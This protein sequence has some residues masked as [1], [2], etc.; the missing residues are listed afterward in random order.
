MDT[1]LS[2]VS[3]AENRIFRKKWG[4]RQGAPFEEEE[5]AFETLLDPLCAVVVVDADVAELVDDRGDGGFSSKKN[6]H[7][8][9]ID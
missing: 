9:C 1:A 3:R 7:V 6:L 4:E 5:G 2:I 8:A